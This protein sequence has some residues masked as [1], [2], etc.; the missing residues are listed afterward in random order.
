MARSKRAGTTGQNAPS[1]SLARARR[2]AVRVPP[3]TVEAGK[4]IVNL[5]VTGMLRCA[6]DTTGTQQMIF[7][8]SRNMKFSGGVASARDPLPF[9]Q[10][11]STTTNPM[12]GPEDVLSFE[13][14]PVR[15]PGGG[16]SIPD[17]FS[18]RVRVR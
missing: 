7:T 6:K 13:L 17:Q 10:G 3:V 8:T 1:G 14:P 16:P 11:T 4:T 12:P 15:V 5:Q 2:G 18:I 9:V